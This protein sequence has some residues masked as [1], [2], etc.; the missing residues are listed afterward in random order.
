[1]EI[2][3]H[4][5]KDG[6]RT[7]FSTNDKYARVIAKD[8]RKGA[9]GDKQLGRTAYSIAFTTD[10]CIYTKYVI[11]K[12]SLRSFATGTIAFSV[13]IG[14]MET[15]KAQDILKLLEE[16]YISYDAKYI[17][18]NYL[19]R[20]ELELIIEKWDFVDELLSQYRTTPKI[21]LPETISTGT[22][23]PAIIYYH[24]Q[25]ELLE[26]FDH[27]FQPEYNDYSQILLI[28]IDLKGDT[29]PLI[30]LKNSG[31]ELKDIDLKNN[32]LYLAN[33]KQFKDLKI[34]KK[35]KN[36]LEEINNNQ[37]RLK[38]EISILYEKNNTFYFPIEASGKLIDSNSEI[39]NF[40]EKKGNQIFIRDLA[41]SRPKPKIKTITF[42]IKDRKGFPMSD[43]QIICKSHNYIV[44]TATNN[45]ISFEAEEIGQ[46]WTVSANKSIE[47][48]S[49]AKTILPDNEN[50]T[51][52]LILKEH[53]TVKFVVKDAENGDNIE[54][55]KV[56]IQGKVN[57]REISEFE[58]VGEDFE[59]TWNISFEKTGYCRSENIEFNPRS[60]TDTIDAKIKKSINPP[61]FP[62]KSDDNEELSKRKKFP[63]LPLIII[64]T[65]VSIIVI[66]ISIWLLYFNVDTVKDTRSLEE[67][68]IITYLEGINLDSDTINYYKNEWSKFNPNTK[69]NKKSWFSIIGIGDNKRE[70]KDSIEY[71]NWEKVSKSIDRAIAKRHYIDSYNFDS[72]RSLRYSDKQQIFKSAVM[73]IDSSKYDLVKN[74]LRN[75]SSLGL[76]QIADSINLILKDSISNKET[77]E[78]ENSK[79]IKNGELE[80][81]TKKSVEEPK[82]TEQKNPTP[83]ISNNITKE[84]QSGTITKQ[85]LDE[86]K[87]KGLAHHKKSID[88]YLEFWSLV[89]NNQKIVFDNLLKKVKRDQILKNS[90]L[91]KFLESICTSSEAFEKYNIAPGKVTANTIKDL[92]EKIK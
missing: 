65:A 25:D 12:D 21:G 62:I 50:D 64:T 47:L 69:P 15:M 40:L 10:G 70:K 82:K 36:G 20:G 84:L 35:G 59:K 75:I 52:E 9:Q 55:F 18:N 2:V 29:N 91:K 19:N 33:S 37:I 87:A 8:I 85:Q 67:K 76:D 43:V 60:N 3:I 34:F 66:G 23:D 92:R 73:N 80:K 13:F 58:F 27:P 11:V 88:L 17:K 74:R 45:Q 26:Y 89:S 68:Q 14:Q 86:L 63:V 77:L 78:A 44:K 61:I 22:K 1:M 16:L 90:E 79:E 7:L 81:V 41:F 53:K 28:H 72:L 24:N 49:A 6:Y 56:Y 48:F 32:I 46:Q 39:H 42:Q 83:K 51:I 38:D 30:V 4:G 71:I 54:N 31:I 57:T 5:T